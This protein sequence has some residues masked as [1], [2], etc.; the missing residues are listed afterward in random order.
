MEL[1]EISAVNNNM[2]GQRYSIGK[3]ALKGGDAF[4][5][6]QWMSCRVKDLFKRRAESKVRCVAGSLPHKSH[7]GVQTLY[8]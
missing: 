3:T 1:F 7:L 4:E 6:R 5:T 2:N 8:M